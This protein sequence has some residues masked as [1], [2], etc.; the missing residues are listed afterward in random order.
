MQSPQPALP[1]RDDNILG[2]CQAVGD[3]FGFNPLWLRI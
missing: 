3:D 2:I 1:F